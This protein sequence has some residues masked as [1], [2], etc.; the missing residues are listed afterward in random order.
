MV[1][2]IVLLEKILTIKQGSLAV[3]SVEHYLK[4]WNQRDKNPNDRFLIRDQ[5]DKEMEV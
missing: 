3:N 1:W 2:I 5:G 4:M